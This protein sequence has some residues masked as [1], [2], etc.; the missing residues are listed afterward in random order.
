ML[1]LWL[2]SVV[3]I[4]V[5]M[6]LVTVRRAQVVQMLFVITFDAADE[7]QSAPIHSTQIHD[8]L[9][10]MDCFSHLVSPSTQTTLPHSALLQALVS[11]S[12]PV[13]KFLLF[14][15]F[16]EKLLCHWSCHQQGH[17][18]PLLYP[19]CW[20]SDGSVVYMCPR[21]LLIWERDLNIF[22]LC[23]ICEKAPYQPTNQQQ[24]KQ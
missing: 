1:S 18:P 20:V 16:P 10:Q 11:N 7:P 17:T 21:A 19:V 9:W 6:E 14:L 24:P 13:I 5:W 3:V 22:F 23:W 2:C 12:S 15:Y 8:H 4:S